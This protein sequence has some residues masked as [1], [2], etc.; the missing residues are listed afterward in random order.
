MRAAAV[1][2]ATAAMLTVSDALFRQYDALKRRQAALDYDDLILE[3]RKLLRTVGMPPWVL[4]KLDGGIDHI[5]IDEAQDTSPEQWDLVHALTAEFFS[6]VGARDARRTV[7]A[8]GDAKQSI[9]SFQGADPASFAAWSR[10]LGETVTP[11]GRRLS[12]LALQ[13][14]FRSAPAILALV[15]RVFADPQARDGLGEA[16]V[17]HVAHRAG[18]AGLVE[19]WPVFETEPGDRPDPWT[20]PVERRDRRTAL[21]RLAAHLVETIH[22]WIGRE[23]LPAR[24][25]AVQPGDLMVLVRRRNAL[26]DALLRGLKARGVPVAGADRMRLTEQLA[27]MDLMALGRFL[28]LPEDDL[29]LAEALKSPLFELDDDDLFALAWDRKGTLWRALQAKSTE[30]P[31]FAAA[32]AELEALLARADFAPPHELYAEFLSARGGRRRLLARLGPDADD[33]LAEF[34]A[35]ALIY[36]RQ[37]PPSLQGFLHWLERGETEVKRDP[38]QR[39]DELRIMTVHG[40]KGLQAPIVILPDT[41]QM[42]NARDSLLWDGNMPLWSPRSALDDARAAA[43]RRAMRQAELREHHRLL[44]VAMTRAEDRLYVCGYTGPRPRLDGT[45]YRLVEQAMA[46]AETVPWPDGR[47]LRRLANPQTGDVQLEPAAAALDLPPGL[48]DFARPAPAE[49]EPPRPLA[50]S[51]PSGP[52][53]PVRSPLVGAEGDRFRRGRLMHRLLQGLPALP[54]A[55]RAAAARRLL[56]SPMHALAPEAAEALVAEALAVLDDPAFAPVFGPGSAA[57]VPIVGRVGGTVISGQ[58]DRLVV[59]QDAVMVVDFKTDRP[60]P[61]QPQDVPV[62][63]LR[64]MAAYAAALGAVYPDRPVRSALLWTDGP[65]LMHLPAD[66]LAPHRPGGLP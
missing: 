16:R 56:A 22:G 9:F 3:T 50:P 53:P 37:H 55:A 49:P 1:A 59:A 33:P 39:R 21:D 19:L 43:A 8:V 52:E 13:V 4:Y 38:E 24:G 25:R 7:F 66:L 42:P 51:R 27:V 63:Y 54:H 36:E 18:A 23:M 65:R 41:C 47:A 34:L 44:Y 61:M 5:L 26:V 6:G 64:Q 58:V 40:A 12:E 14:S 45:W 32:R 11:T 15:D 20:P 30:R 62:I 2:K 17:E 31:R 35:Q 60:P 28:V 46:D 29:S 48:P 10:E 57:E